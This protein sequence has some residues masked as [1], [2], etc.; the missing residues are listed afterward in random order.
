MLEPGSTDTLSMS[1]SAP[2]RGWYLASATACGAYLGI[3]LASGGGVSPVITEVMANP[4]E[5]ASQEFIE[6]HYPGPGVFL[7]GGCSFTDGDAVDIVTPLSGTSLLEGG[8]CGVILDPDYSGGLPIPQGTPL[9]TPGNSSLGNGLATDDPVVLYDRNGT[10]VENIL[11]TAGTPALSNDPLQ[12]DDDGL[13]GIPFNPGQGRSMVRVN[14]AAPDREYN[15][16]ASG[17]G[18]SPGWLDDCGA[19]ADVMADTIIAPAWVTPMSPFQLAGVFT[20]VGAAAASNV[21]LF[22]FNDLDADSCPDASE[23]ITTAFIDSLAPGESFTLEGSAVLPDHGFFL[24]RALADCSADTVPANDQKSVTVMCGEGSFPVITEVLCNP[25]D[26]SRDEF[27]ELF[28][29]GPGVVD[30]SIFSLSDGDAVDALHGDFLIS[31]RYALILDPDYF[32]GAMPHEIP[33]GTPV[34]LP[35]NSAIG[36]GLS[37]GDPVSLI[38]GTTVVSTYGTPDNPDDGIPCGPATDMSIELLSPGLP[39][40]EANWFVNPLGPSPGQPPLGLCQGTDYGMRG[41]CLSPPAGNEGTAVTLRATVESLG[42]ET[43]AITVLFRAG[44]TGIGSSSPPPPAPGDSVCVE[45]QWVSSGSGTPVEALV[46]CAED[47]N[48]G[49]DGK[50][51]PWDPDPGLAI[52]EIMYSPGTPGPEWVELYN[53]TG[54]SVELSSYVFSDPD[55]AAALP[56]YLLEPGAYAILCPDAQGFSD[57]WSG[58]QCAV[59]TPSC[60]PTLNN[61]GDTLSLGDGTLTDWVPFSADWG[62]GSNVSLERRSPAERGWLAE[63]WGSCTTGA[64]PGRANSICGQQGGPFLS[65]WPEVFSPDGDGVDDRIEITLNVPGQGCSAEARVYDVTGRV[66]AELWNGPVPGVTLVLSW[67]GAGMPVGR[68]IV[69]ACA[70][71]GNSLLEGALVRVLARRL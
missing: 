41:L 11:G 17:E 8:A 61:A 50:T 12:C 58:V 39:D 64:T 62:G 57:A 15:W 19:G 4:W 37:G 7:L 43:G 35:G 47:E 29:P 24:L 2:A 32:S 23:V 31:G 56:G 13:D 66:V 70:R 1:F 68:Y 36:D 22:L 53:G 48:P 30:P 21:E 55:A 20:S 52:N 16:A 6:V 10:G 5:Q 60:W 3:P 42:T 33:P 14:P 40:A 9:F 18:G 27:I 59:L 71:N 34:V 26:Q 45:L 38:F 25:S 65:A 51:V 28:L 44:G 46:Q 69:F 63:N 67:D 54:S 49:N